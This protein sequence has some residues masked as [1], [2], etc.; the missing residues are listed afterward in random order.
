MDALGVSLVFEPMGWATWLA[1]VAAGLL[2]AEA[3]SLLAPLR[4]KGPAAFW[5]VVAAALAGGA[6]L[7][8][9]WV[10]WAGPVTPLARPLSGPLPMLERVALPAAL[11]ALTACVLLAAWAIVHRL[12]AALGGGASVGQ[13]LGTLA[14]GLGTVALAA[15]TAFWVPRGA[16][17]AIAGASVSWAVRGYRRTTSP[18]R[19]GVKG[20]LLGLRILALLVLAAW[21]ARPALEYRHKEDVKTVL[22]VCADTSASMQQRDEGLDRDGPLGLA[23]E[24]ISRIRAVREALAGQQAA[25]EDLADKA[26][27]ELAAFSA[28]ASPPESFLPD[29]GWSLA[30]LLAAD[31]RATALGDAVAEA[32][33]LYAARQQTVGAIVLISDGGNN[34]S[35]VLDPEKLAALMGSRGV[36]VHTV[37]VGS[38]RATTAIKTLTVRDLAAPDEID[39]FHR[40]PIAAE[41]EAIGLEGRQVKLTC[42]FGAEEIGS[43]VV[44]VNR[45]RWTHPLR[46]VHVPLRAGF[47]RVRVSAELLGGGQKDLA[48]RPDAG[49]LVHVVDREMRI[50]YVEGTFRYEAKY[51]AQALA[52]ARRFAI[53]R[54]ILLQPLGAGQPPP[55]SEELDDWLAYH[56]ILFGDVAASHFT[57][58]Q[59]EIVR[60]LVGKYGK[61]FC[62][63]GGSRSFG[64]GGWEGTPIADVLPVDPAA[65]AGQID[66]PVRVVP[67][68]AGR[69]SDLMRIGADGQDIAAA[70]TSL[71]ALPGANRLGGLK[72]GATVL[73]EGPGGAPLIVTQPYGKGR[74]MAVAF[75]TTWRWVLTPKDTAELQR[76]F[77]RQVCLHLAAPQGTVWIVTDRTSYDLSRLRRGSEVVRVSAGVE[78]PQGRPLLDVPV[79]VRLVGPDGKESPLTLRPAEKMRQ[80]QLTPPAR[81][82]VYT[83]R[84]ATQVDGKPLAAEGQ[85]EVLQ[86]DLEALELLANHDLLRRMAA[87]SD[88]QFFR[89]PQLGALLDDLRLRTRPEQRDTVTHVRLS[90][91]LRWPAILAILALLCAE[92]ALRKRKG[93][94]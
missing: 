83:L 50:L 44:V 20:L 8:W 3:A 76:R 89:L 87:L 81:P 55:L 32:F 43:E 22:L 64:R 39:A 42:H 52:A 56:G 34:T 54:R 4:K 27:V 93:L 67:T 66:A 14:A 77:W 70:W 46:F 36:P 29:V 7:A 12:A 75:D 78:D 94:V 6:V 85:F 68:R 11:S 63:V 9:V 13:M 59:L 80:G 40:L 60:E 57:R 65:S 61:G 47:H 23:P 35:D 17:A 37:G 16:I 79:Q 45:L 86:R 73:A 2:L 24:P 69:Q 30:A 18:V 51:I 58:R 92:W 31:G 15:A 62:M 33:E 38:D 91:R 41:A 19:R 48:G 25:F 71:D 84:I 28:A 21:A 26:D 49:K 72:P 53:D 88:G 74:A 10:S 5:A 1:A 90:A 82:G